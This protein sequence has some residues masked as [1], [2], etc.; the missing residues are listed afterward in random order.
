MIVNPPVDHKLILLITMSLAAETI[1]SSSAPSRKF[2][3]NHSSSKPSNNTKN[4]T[5][6]RPRVNSAAFTAYETKKIACEARIKDIVARMDA[7]KN[8]YSM[9]GG[10]NLS[11][12]NYK[13]RGELIE[14]LKVLRGEL[15][16]FD[17][18]RRVISNQFSET[19]ET[20]KK[21]VITYIIIIIVLY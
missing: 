21:K 4:N 16:G 1:S 2:S 17:D 9:A 18:E 15:K 5:D 19:L 10:E 12:K 20:L 6:E 7:V 8:G 14:K 11:E 13:L 3:S